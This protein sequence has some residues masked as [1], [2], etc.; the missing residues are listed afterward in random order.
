MVMWSDWKEKLKEEPKINSSLLWEYD[1]ENFDWQ[2]M[3]DTVVQRVIERGW[4]NDFYAI[5]NLYGG[6]DGVRD[7]IKNEVKILSDKEIAFVCSIFKLKKE[8]LKC[9]IRKQ[10]RMKLLNS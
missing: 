2:Y 5:F 8:E 10:S 3:R 6:I 4:N 9:Y 1:L 7:I